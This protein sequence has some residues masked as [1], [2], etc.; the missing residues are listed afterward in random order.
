MQ[1]WK[2][3]NI[4]LHNFNLF[5]FQKMNKLNL[6]MIKFLHIIKNGIKL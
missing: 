2:N 5:F 1:N 6:I 3:A 4:S